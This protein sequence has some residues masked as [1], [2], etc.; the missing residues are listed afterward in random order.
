MASEDEMNSPAY[1]LFA[2]AV[3]LFILVF[4]PLVAVLSLIAF[5]QERSESVRR[6]KDGKLPKH[7]HWADSYDPGE[8][9]EPREDHE[10]G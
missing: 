2:I 3:G 1:W 8:S 5:T 4:L 9:S 10:R 7:L 6:R